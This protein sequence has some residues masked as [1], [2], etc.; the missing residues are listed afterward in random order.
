M[1]KITFIFL[2]LVLTIQLKAQQAITVAQQ[3]FIQNRAK[4]KVK[5]YTEYLELLART[6]SKAIDER[7][8]IKQTIYLSFGKEGPQTRINNDLIP[9]VIQTA[10][11][12]EKSIQLESYLNKIK[13]LYGDSLSLTYSNLEVSDV[14][15]NQADNNYFVKV[16]ADRKIDGVFQHASEKTP[17]SSGDKVDFFINANLV[18]NQIKMG[19]IYGVQPHTE[20]EFVK[21]KVVKGAEGAESLVLIGKP[22]K[23][24]PETIRKKFKRGKEY[25]IAW[26]GGM[27]DDIIK[28]ELM[29]KD[30]LKAKKKIYNSMLNN[31]TFTFT[32]SS[33]IKIGTYQFLISNIS[34]SRSTQTSN[35]DIRRKI[36]LAVLAVGIPAVAAAG[37][38]AVIMLTPDANN[39]TPN[40][41]IADPPGPPAQ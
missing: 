29:P 28:V 6:R 27:A 33:D 26:E 8:Q 36:P 30:T 20:K 25:T 40:E 23:V 1:S 19:G 41:N 16:V 3:Q 5:T 38:V 31:N 35:F 17:Y 13:E 18:N 12:M 4:S 22:I 9:P 10:M 14:Y 34:T 2:F 39:P 24:K 37:V 21:A 11:A 32:P 7:D 15:Y